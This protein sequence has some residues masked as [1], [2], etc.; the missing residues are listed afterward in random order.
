M[1]ELYRAAEKPAVRALTM[2]RHLLEVRELVYDGNL[3]EAGKLL[4]GFRAHLAFLDFELARLE[5]EM[6]AAL[7]AGHGGHAARAARE[8]P[9]E[10]SH[11]PQL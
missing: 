6:R 5:S 2:S 1:S 9:P 11:A 7:A 8:G 10:V 4:R 3:A